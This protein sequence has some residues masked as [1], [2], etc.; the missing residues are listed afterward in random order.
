M[1]ANWNWQNGLQ[2]IEIY[3]ERMNAVAFFGNVSCNR[4]GGTLIK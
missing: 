3:D 4:E 1:F 2:G